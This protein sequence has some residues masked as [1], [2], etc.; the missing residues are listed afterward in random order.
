MEIPELLLVTS[1]SYL[2]PSKWGLDFPRAFW[3]QLSVLQ[4]QITRKKADL[5]SLDQMSIALGYNYMDQTW[6]SSSPSSAEAVETVSR[7]EGMGR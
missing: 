5:S 7:E 2:L 6:S 3:L 4:L 1:D